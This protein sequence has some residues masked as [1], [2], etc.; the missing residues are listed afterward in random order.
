MKDRIPVNPGRVLITPED[1]SAA[2]YAT[3][4]R[5]DNPT[6]EGTKLNKANL[7]KDA[8]AALFEYGNGAVPDNIFEF[9]GKYNLH[10]WKRRPVGQH[11]EEKRTVTTGQTIV[12]SKS[13]KDATYTIKYAD[14]VF[15]DPDTLAVSLVNPVSLAVSFNNQDSTFPSLL[16]KYATNFSSGT[17]VI[18]YI[19]TNAKYTCYTDPYETVFQAGIYTVSGQTVADIGSWEYLRSSDESAYPDSGESGGYEYQYLGVPFD[20]AVNG[21]KIEAGVY[22]GTGTYGS[23]NPCSLTF[24]FVP[25]ILII[26]GVLKSK[27]TTISGVGSVV[28]NISYGYYGESYSEYSIRGNVQSIGNQVQWYSD[29]AA[30]EQMNTS[31]NTYYYVAIG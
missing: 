20:N 22:T 14:A 28:M 15:I 30:S 10:W 19:P 25:S 8:T 13:S 2:F 16:G 12:S 23:S 11:V 4:T 3:I 1:G 18:Y 29:N 17:S 26:S 21:A 9:L 7:L 5:A 31:G 6:E 27:S 24:D